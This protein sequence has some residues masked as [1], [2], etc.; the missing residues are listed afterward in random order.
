M[1]GLLSHRR[2]DI[3]N[4]FWT[5]RGL[6][7]E[8]NIKIRSPLI[9]ID[10][11]RRTPLLPLWRQPE[12]RRHFWP[13]QQQTNWLLTSACNFI[14]RPLDTTPPPP[15]ALEYVQSTAISTWVG[16]QPGILLRRAEL[17]N[18]PKPSACY[19]TDPRSSGMRLEM[20]FLVKL[21]CFRSCFHCYY[22]TTTTTT[23][24]TITT[25]AAAAE[26]LSTI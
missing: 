17:S 13:R 2:I 8:Q 4:L 23:T 21:M 12:W 5:N 14:R 26:V 1:P 22:Y 6:M 9:E 19:S 20:C 10:F 18:W 3:T 24:T 7:V 16:R 15:V 25:A 11:C